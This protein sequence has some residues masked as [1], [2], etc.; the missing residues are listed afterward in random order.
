MKLR[1]CCAVTEDIR[2][3]PVSLLAECLMVVELTDHDDM[4]MIRK[5]KI[6]GNLKG[7]ICRAVLNAF[8]QSNNIKLEVL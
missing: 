1:E 5:N 8:L 7:G 3:I 2:S 4:Y 6:D